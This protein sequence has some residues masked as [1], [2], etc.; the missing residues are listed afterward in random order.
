MNTIIVSNL[1]HRPVRTLISVIAVAVEVILILL[2]VGLFT[3]LLES[4][5]ERTRNLGDVM[6]R[7]PGSSMLIGMSSAP[8]S[9]KYAD[10]V[11]RQP[12]VAAVTPVF[13][14]LGTEGSVDVI[15]G[16]DLPSFQATAGP[17]T[18]LQGGPFTSAD[19]ILVDDTYATSKHVSLGSKIT[20]FNH[21]FTISGVVASGKGGRRFLPLATMQDLLGAQGKASAFFVKADSPANA[22][23][24]ADEIKSV[25][26]MQT[27][28]VLTMKEWL[29][30]MTPESLPG[31]SSA[32]NIAIG[33][34]VVIGFIV[35]FQ[36]MYAAV[37]ERTREIGIL[38]SLGAGKGYIVNLVLRETVLLALFGIAAGIGLSYAARTVIQHRIATIPIRL[39]PAWDMRATIIAICGA[40]LGALYPAIKAARK[41]P[42]DAL[43]Y[44]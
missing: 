3:G 31:F 14:Q 33:V 36:A 15:W 8:I 9:V 42:I 41:D 12:H 13:W 37:M 16:I 22:G 26:G 44:E 7:P 28:S 6:V 32:I 35:I 30:L 25:Q 4:S 5:K 17:F 20:L 10:I 34:A 27:W 38:K 43:A 40:I 11:R 1:V 19:S 24:I 18:F 2:I 21:D 23:A 29:S 39:T